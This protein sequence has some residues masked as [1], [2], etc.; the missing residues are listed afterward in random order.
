M[1]QRTPPFRPPPPG[2]PPGGPKTQ[3][4]LKSPPASQ[5]KPPPGSQMKTPGLSLSPGAQ[6]QGGQGQGNPPGGNGTPSGQ[7]LD[8]GT[9]SFASPIQRRYWQ[10]RRSSLTAADIHAIHLNNDVTGPEGQQFPVPN[11]PFSAQAPVV[12][13]TKSQAALPVRM[14]TID[15]HPL[16]LKMTPTDRDVFVPR[17]TWDKTQRDQLKPEEKIAFLKSATR[18]VLSKT[19]K[20]SVLTTKVDD[21]G[22]LTHVH[23]LAAQVKVLRNHIVD[24]DLIDVFTI[25]VSQDI[26]QTGINLSVDPDTNSL[27]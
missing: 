24:H 9:I 18:Y 6:A 4:P 15:G 22:I 25:V 2:G 14:V 26:S 10:N 27:L 19:N 5:T 20:L 17:C 7:G 1:F 23:N 8:L 12:S 13:Q 11:T 16:T 3:K 21:D